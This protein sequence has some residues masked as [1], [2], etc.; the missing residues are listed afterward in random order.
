MTKVSKVWSFGL[1]IYLEQLGY[2]GKLGQFTACGVQA[3]QRPEISKL[4][5][6]GE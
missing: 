3:G 4:W 2:L 5:L 1:R 6:L